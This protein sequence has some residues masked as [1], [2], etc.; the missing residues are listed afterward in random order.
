MDFLDDILNMQKEYNAL[1]AEL[2]KLE[3]ALKNVEPAMQLFLAEHE[4][5]KRRMDA[6]FAYLDM[7]DKDW[8]ASVGFTALDG[9]ED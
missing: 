1:M 6:V 7:L 8:R 4:E 9:K 5:L 3:P 2:E